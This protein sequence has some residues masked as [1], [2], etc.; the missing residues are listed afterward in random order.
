[1]QFTISKSWWE[2]HLRVNSRWLEKQK[3]NTPNQLCIP[4]TFFRPLFEHSFPHS[5]TYWKQH[6]AT[7][8][9][10]SQLPFSLSQIPDLQHNKKHSSIYSSKRSVLHAW[11]FHSEPAQAI[12]LL[13]YYVKK[14]HKCKGKVTN[15]SSFFT[16][17]S[18]QGMESRTFYHN[19]TF[20]SLTLVKWDKL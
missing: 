3:A 1:M 9:A 8:P 5:L 4:N 10:L 6:M 7:K 14:M 17:D 19:R 2:T 18:S 11:C 15:T 20:L 13:H 16:Q 12:C